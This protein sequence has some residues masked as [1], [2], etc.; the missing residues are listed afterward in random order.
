MTADIPN[1]AGLGS[2]TTGVLRAADDWAFAKL[3][4]A[5]KAAPGAGRALVKL[6]DGTGHVAQQPPTWAVAACA[7]AGGGGAGRRAAARGSVCY[8]V[9]AVVANFLVKPLVRRR[10]PPRARRQ[11][12][13]PVTSSF[14]SGHSATHVA[15]V[16]GASREL[17]QSFVPLAALAVVAHW[18]L[19]R[20]HG[21]YASDV[22]AGGLIGMAV[23]WA[24]G[25][26]WPSSSSPPP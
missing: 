14:P 12:V 6:L 9:S 16:L 20:S 1:P 13:G 17:P 10:R 19:V 23:T 11:L 4:G 25:R 18:S 8:A 26:L 2:T 21:H 24:M 3:D 5:A 22:V 15:F 7:L